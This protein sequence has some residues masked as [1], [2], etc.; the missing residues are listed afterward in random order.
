LRQRNEIHFGFLIDT[1]GPKQKSKSYRFNNQ[2]LIEPQKV[3]TYEI[4]SRE[5]YVSLA[6][7]MLLTESLMP[8]VL[9]A[10]LKLLQKEQF[11][12]NVIFFK[13]EI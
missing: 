5:Y 4:C 3:L 2:N 7:L 8:V 10:E 1:I 13:A 6:L 9:L 11:F 12:Y